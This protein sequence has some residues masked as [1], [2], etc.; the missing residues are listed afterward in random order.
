MPKIISLFCTALFLGLPSL[1]LAQSSN[2]HL[3]IDPNTL[4]P[5]FKKTAQPKVS[6]Q[7]VWTH[8]TAPQNLIN[9][10][11]SYH[12][13]HTADNTLI[14]DSGF[15]KYSPNQGPAADASLRDN[16]PVTSGIP[17]WSATA[18]G[19]MNGQK[20]ETDEKKIMIG[21]RIG[22]LGVTDGPTDDFVTLGVAGRYRVNNNWL[23]GA[24]VDYTEF[25]LQRPYQYLGL[26]S[27]G[28]HDA[29]ASNTIISAF[30][31]RE[32][33]SDLQNN[34]KP[35]ITGGLGIG[36]TNVEDVRGKLAGGG[37]YNID[38][39]GGTEIIPSLGVGIRFNL[40]N[41]WKLEV[42]ARA[43]YHIADWNI[44]DKTS[45]RS[46]SVDDYLTLGGYLSLIF[47]F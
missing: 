30:A 38:T 9:Y 20:A 12:S 28:S 13:F 27:L 44:N 33:D 43:D 40:G 24:A 41:Q 4:Y 16:Y 11:P 32:F 1:T 17:L 26:N 39:D 18:P 5:N 19:L 22:L 29:S 23:I 47:D 46:S 36:L 8:N 10:S 21:P 42:G 31:E 45:G 35:F 37:T 34:I 7:A 2:R 3:D 15:A 6:N 14:R 25:D